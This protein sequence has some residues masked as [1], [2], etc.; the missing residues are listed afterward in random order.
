MET[1]A[2]LDDRPAKRI[3]EG[4]FLQPTTLQTPTAARWIHRGRASSLSDC[5]GIWAKDYI[6]SHHWTEPG[7][8]VLIETRDDLRFHSQ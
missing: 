1:V 3:D 5:D 8:S 6:D 4:L 2:T 7:S